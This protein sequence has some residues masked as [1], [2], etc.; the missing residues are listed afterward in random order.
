MNDGNTNVDEVS[1]SVGFN[2]HSYFTN[3]FRKQY[4]KTPFQ[5]INDLKSSS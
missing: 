2:S 4:E 3:S 5:Y 1:Y